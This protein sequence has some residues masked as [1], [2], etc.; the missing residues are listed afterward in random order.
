MVKLCR[1]FLPSLSA[2]AFDDPRT[3]LRFMDGV[4]FV[5]ETDDR[6]D[7]IV[8]D[9]TDPIGPGEVLFT[10]SFYAD[11]AR[12]LTES[13]ILVTQSGVT[14]MQESEAA[15]TYRR[16]K[17]LFADAALYVTQVPTYGAGFMTLGWG[18]HSAAPRA[19]APAEIE[20]RVAALDLKGRYYSPTAH[21]AS[22]GVPAY[23]ERLMRD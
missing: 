20:R 11:C 21:V 18:C 9:S 22:F 5:A 4:K 15:A 16:M 12:C 6:F 17:K 14:F 1:E 7:V 13:G 19:T 10:D 23:I 2:G 8:V 3:D